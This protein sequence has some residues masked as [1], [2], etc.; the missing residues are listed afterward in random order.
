VGNVPLSQN[1]NNLKKI[2]GQYGKI[3]K[4]WFRSI[5]VEQTK[6]KRKANCIL[7]NYQEGADSK[8]AYVKFE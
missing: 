4:V 2:F 8:N 3:S 7:K 1:H 6:L 5:P